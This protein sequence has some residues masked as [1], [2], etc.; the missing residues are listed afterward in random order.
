[1]FGFSDSTG[2]GAPR[3]VVRETSKVVKRS[4]DFFMAEIV[5]QRDHSR[6]P[7]GVVCDHKVCDFQVKEPPPSKSL[8]GEIRRIYPDQIFFRKVWCHW[9]CNEPICA[10][11]HFRRRDISRAITMKTLLFRLGKKDIASKTL[12]VDVTSKMNPSSLL[13]L[14]N[15]IRR[16]DLLDRL[17]EGWEKGKDMKGGDYNYIKRFSQRMKKDQ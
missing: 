7:S 4:D 16:L 6:H 12:V 9:Q 5:E 1:M 3:R 11:D 13:Y 2:A 17:P 14:L 10:G 15:S 8:T